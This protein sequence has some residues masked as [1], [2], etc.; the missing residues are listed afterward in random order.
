MYNKI[1]KPFF[2][3]LE[4]KEIDYE[5]KAVHLL[6]EGGQQV[7]ITQIFIWIDVPVTWIIVFYLECRWVQIHES[8]GTSTCIGDWRHSFDTVGEV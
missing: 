2:P 7:Y 5:Y 1:T 4:W 3:A 6:N 8:H